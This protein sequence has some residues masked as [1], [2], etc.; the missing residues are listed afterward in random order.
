MMLSKAI[1]A[2]IAELRATGK[3]AQT[4]AAYES[5]LRR[6]A[7]NAKHDSVLAFTA[8]LVKNHLIMLSSQDNAAMAT[9]HRKRAAYGQFSKWCVRNDVFK[10]DPLA[11][12]PT[13]KRPK[14]LPRPYNDEEIAALWALDL[15]LMEQVARG[16]LF[17][18]GLRVSPICRLKVGDV[19][20]HPPYLR[21]IV[22][23][24]K[25]VQKE[26]PPELAGLIQGY[27]LSSTDLKGQTPLIRAKRGGAMRRQKF[28]QM[29]ARWGT[30]AGVADCTP[31]RFRHTFGTK[32]L[33]LTKNLR[34]VQE[35]M[36]HEDISSTTIYTKVVPG[37]V[38]RA[39]S[40]LPWTRLLPQSSVPHGPSTPESPPSG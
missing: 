16:I 4:R 28:E 1:T 5:D 13:I 7:A 30:A 40:A 32:L 36:D 21:T 2:F 11:G 3:A 27:V 20:Y 39:M 25:V 15:P 22:K 17:M 8:E 24:S 34:L 12:L 35:A 10:A 6:L 33:E 31:H 26:M 18:T 14:H 29:A 19:S 23:G 37:D 38:G 9:L